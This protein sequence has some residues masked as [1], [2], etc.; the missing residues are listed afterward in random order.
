MKVDILAFG[1]HPD[2]IELS[3]SGTIL[4]HISLGKTVAICD[5]TQGELGSRG[6]AE[7]RLQEAEKAR[8]I[9]AVDY[10]ENLGLRDAFFE[11]NEVSLLAII[12][13]IRKY[14]PEIVLA[15]SLSDR[16][17]DHGRAAQLVSRASFLSGLQK[18]NTNQE[19][20]RPRAI[21][22]YI[23]DQNLKPDFVVDI[24]E[25]IDQK[26]ESILAY[27]T[28]F[29]NPEHKAQET[30]ISSKQFLEFIKGKART[31][32]RDIQVDFAEGFNVGRTPG[33]NNLLDLS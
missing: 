9:M 19:K 12:K 4:K 5:L 10:R 15:N 21:Y 29:Y 13:V 33:V 7:I 24:T 27:G 28:Q 32:G 1:A 20:W 26:I 31:F 8:Q 2:D 22:H 18:I 25:Y 17:P 16:H 11:I 3:C 6:S 23:Q 30:P 14:K